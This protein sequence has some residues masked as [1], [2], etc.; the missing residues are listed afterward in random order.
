MEPKEM[1][2]AEKIMQWEQLNAL[3][4]PLGW[5]DH[6]EGSAIFA[7]G[8]GG[9]HDFSAIAM[10]KVVQYAIRKIYETGM[11]YGIESTQRVIRNALGLE[12]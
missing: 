2:E 4:A 10:D 3:L 8:L 5:C 11:N 1:T 9:T 12:K 7:H 6:K